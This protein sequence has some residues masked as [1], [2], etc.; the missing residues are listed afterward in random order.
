MWLGKARGIGQQYVDLEK[1]VNLNYAGLQKILKKHDKLF[2]QAQCRPFYKVGH[3]GRYLGIGA[4]GP[5]MVHTVVQ[6]LACMAEH[7]ERGVGFSCSCVR[8]FPKGSNETLLCM[9]VHISSESWARGDHHDV[10]VCTHACCIV[11]TPSNAK[12]CDKSLI[13]PA[14]ASA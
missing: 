2:P 12:T 5:C 3:K 14:S 6:P 8:A 10:Q 9:Q 4:G 1:F 11:S 7:M 13:L